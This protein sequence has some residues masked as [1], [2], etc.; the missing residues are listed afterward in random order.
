MMGRNP[1]EP[2]TADPRP[3][4]ASRSRFV[5][6]HGELRRALV[7]GIGRR[8]GKVMER[9]SLEEACMDVPLA[10]LY[11]RKLRPTGL[12]GIV[13]RLFLRWWR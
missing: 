9:V 11:R 5:I 8:T 13:E 12:A 1:G 3:G 7:E 2:M 6:A 4:E 10:E